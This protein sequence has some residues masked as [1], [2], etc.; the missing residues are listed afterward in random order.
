VL[1]LLVWRERSS[2]AKVRGTTQRL[3]GEWRFDGLVTEMGPS[4]SRLKT[5]GWMAFPPCVHY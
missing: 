1:I 5:G 4:I 3:L 2:Q